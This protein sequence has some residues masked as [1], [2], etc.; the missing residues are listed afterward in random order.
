MEATVD[1]SGRGGGKADQNQEANDAGNLA[2]KADAD[3]NER[4]A[5]EFGGE[6]KQVRDLPI[7]QI[8]T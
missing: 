8:K 4:V 2:L 3:A 5:S 6:A 7:M 1:I